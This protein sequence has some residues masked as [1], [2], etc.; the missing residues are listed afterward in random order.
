M[1]SVLALACWLQTSD[2]HVLSQADCKV[3]TKVAPTEAQMADLLFAWTVAKF[4]KS[5]AIVFAN[6]GMTTRVLV[7]GK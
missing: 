4:V 2:N 5:N 6:Q 7:L 1:L 3:V